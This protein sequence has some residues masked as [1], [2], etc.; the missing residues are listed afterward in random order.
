MSRNE[1]IPDTRQ[2]IGDG[3]YAGHDGYQVWIW[4]S[5]GIEESNFVA[6]DRRTFSSLIDYGRGVYAARKEETKT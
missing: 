2:Y 5:N 6:L 4:T 3:V 1:T